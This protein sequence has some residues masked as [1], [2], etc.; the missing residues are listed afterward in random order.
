MKAT[1]VKA[2]AEYKIKVT[3]DNGVSGVVDL[4]DLVQKGIFRT[5]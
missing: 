3:F 5:R 2:I 1:D 4:N